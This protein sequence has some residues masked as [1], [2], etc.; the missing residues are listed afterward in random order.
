V[1][2]F[3]D[4]LPDRQVGAENDQMWDFLNCPFSYSYLTLIL[5]NRLIFAVPWEE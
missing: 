2:L 3:F 1:G 5:F 4:F